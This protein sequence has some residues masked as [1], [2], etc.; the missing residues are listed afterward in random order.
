MINLFIAV[1]LDS[2][3]E[4]K[5]AMERERELKMIKVWRTVWQRYDK[6]SKGTLPATTFIEILKQVPK[7]VGFIDPLV[8]NEKLKKKN[9]VATT[10][11][12]RKL[13]QSFSSI[14]LKTLDLEV[15]NH[16]L[17]DEIKTAPKHKDILDLLVRL[18]LFVEKKKVRDRPGMAEEWCV[19][20]QDA[21]LSYA[22]MLAGPEIELGPSPNAQLKSMNAAEWYAQ[23]YD[24][25]DILSEVF[26]AEVQAE[27]SKEMARYMLDVYVDNQEDNSSDKADY[28]HLDT[29]DHGKHVKSSEKGTLVT[30]VDVHKINED[31]TEAGE[32][33]NK[34]SYRF[35]LGKNHFQEMEL[36]K[37]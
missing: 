34:P 2:F 12:P 22:T 1:I 32:L 9:G 5:D 8:F 4:E 7:P 35:D 10:K 25:K 23:E 30:R 26:K 20:Y 29:K 19:N 14:S 13:T 15:Q 37:L 16:T 11:S 21:L 27:R 17:L 31:A 28:N 36:E 6:S 33:D 18:K 24:C 3:N